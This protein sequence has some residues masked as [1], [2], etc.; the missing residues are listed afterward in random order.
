MRR[1]VVAAH[2][3]MGGAACVLRSLPAY[4]ASGEGVPEWIGP[5]LPEVCDSLYARARQLFATLDWHAA[6]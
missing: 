3:V 6:T 4:Y 5:V 1:S 2:D